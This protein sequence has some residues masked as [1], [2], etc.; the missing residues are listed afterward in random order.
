M[1]RKLDE[2]STGVNFTNQIEEGLNANVLMYEYLYNGG[3]VAIADFN[4]DGKDDIYFSA[5]MERNHLYLN[6]GG[7]KFTEV[8]AGAGVEGRP[9]PWKTGVSI[10]DI[11]ADRL[12]DIYLCYSG[13]LPPDKKRNQLFI[14]LGNDP[15]GVP[16]F[17]DQAADYGLDHPGNSTHAVFFDFDRDQDLDMILV[18]HN[19]KSL[20]VLD[21]AST[22]TDLSDP[23]ARSNSTRYFSLQYLA[24][25]HRQ[26]SQSACLGA[27][28][29]FSGGFNRTPDITFGADFTRFSYNTNNLYAPASGMPQGGSFSQADRTVIRGSIAMPQITPGYYLKPKLSFQAN[30]YSGVLTNSP[31][32]SI[33]Q[34]LNQPIQGF[35]LPTL[36]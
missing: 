19:P 31:S 30:Q 9:G 36:S 10:V 17:Q 27:P 3:G 28:G 4:S 24:P 25:S 22:R 12:P 15:S 6:K 7:L 14:N 2:G 33:N 5:N 16:R 35:A 20:P 29:S 26:L 8:A 23:T 32:T 1:F 34:S 13:S 18:N 21:E 11:N